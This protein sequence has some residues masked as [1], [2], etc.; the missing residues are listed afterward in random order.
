MEQAMGQSTQS[1]HIR[2]TAAHARAAD[3]A[4]Y[5]CEPMQR[6]DMRRQGLRILR[7]TAES[8]ALK[9]IPA[10]RPQ[11]VGQGADRHQRTPAP[12]ASHP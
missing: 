7:C 8:M 2:E 3:C 4:D 10:G 12:A 5:P 11:R 9:D 1:G 6:D